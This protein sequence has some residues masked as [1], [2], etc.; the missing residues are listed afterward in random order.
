MSGIFQFL[1]HIYVLIQVRTSGM[2]NSTFVAENVLVNNK[3]S[4]S[5][6]NEE[7]SWIC[8]HIP[9]KLILTAGYLL[10]S[11]NA[12]YQHIRQWRVE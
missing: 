10:R 12:N 9:S 5:S 4:W 2:F 1:Q 11:W 8:F 7:L 3:E 6:L